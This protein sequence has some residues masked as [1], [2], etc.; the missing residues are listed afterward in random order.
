[1]AEKTARVGFRWRPETRAALQKAS[2][3]E[4]RSLSDL[5]ERIVAEWLARNGVN[6]RRDGK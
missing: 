5:A 2:R 3:D 4:G 1:M 6:K